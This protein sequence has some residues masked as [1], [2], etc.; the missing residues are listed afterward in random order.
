M[1]LFLLVVYL[2]ERS[3]EG[4]RLTAIARFLVILKPAMCL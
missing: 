4:R 1:A 2:K 3:I